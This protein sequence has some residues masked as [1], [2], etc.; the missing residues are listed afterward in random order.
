[1]NRWFAVG[2]LWLIGSP[3]ATAQLFDYSSDR[4][5][6]LE[7]CDG[8]FH[9][10]ERPQA[11]SCYA[12]LLIES[13]DATVRAEAAWRTGDLQAANAYFRTA[14]EIEPESPRA[15]TR[16][17]RLFLTTHQNSEAIKLFQE[18]LELDDGYLPA[19]LGLA[20]LAAGRFDDRALALV[21]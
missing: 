16:W 10:G 19:K 7:P 15:R 17:G 5:A 12:A 1:M 6:S 18:A 11:N 4:D 14:V 2:C 20:A 13:D 3:L 8:L 21:E 9:S